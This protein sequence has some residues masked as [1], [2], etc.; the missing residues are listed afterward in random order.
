MAKE[1]TETEWGF[2]YAERCRHVCSLLGFRWWRVVALIPLVERRSILR[3]VHNWHGLKFRRRIGAS[4]RVRKVSP[5]VLDSGEARPTADDFAAFESVEDGI[6][7]FVAFVRR[8]HYRHPMLDDDRVDDL[9][10]V[11]WLWLSGYATGRRYV[12][13]F[14]RRCQ[15]LGSVTRSTDQGL[16]DELHSLAVTKIDAGLASVL[17]DGR[18]LRY[19]RQRRRY[20]RQAL[21]DTLLGH[22]T[23]MQVLDFDLPECNEWRLAR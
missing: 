3:D 19:G 18:S 10:F 5:E 8:R 6:A 13:T 17:E 2:W 11:A 7:G 22:P 15:Y 16:D 21:A 1:G 20:G 9:R 23:K 14:A 12:E 4:G